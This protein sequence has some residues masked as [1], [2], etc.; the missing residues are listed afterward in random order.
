MRVAFVGLGNMGFPMAGHI[1]RSKLLSAFC[2]SGEE[3]ATPEPWT[4]MVSGLTLA[5]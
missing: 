3:S 5:L 2:M 1:A 4:T